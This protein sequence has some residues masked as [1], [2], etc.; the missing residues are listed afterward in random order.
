[1]RSILTNSRSRL[2]DDVHRDHAHCS[3][4]TYDVNVNRLFH[5]LHLQRCISDNH[6]YINTSDCQLVAVTL[7]MINTHSPLLQPNKL[8]DSQGLGAHLPT[9]LPQRCQKC[10]TFQKLQ[11]FYSAPFRQNKKKFYETIKTSS[12]VCT[13]F[14]VCTLAFCSVY[15]LSLYK[16]QASRSVP[17]VPTYH[18]HK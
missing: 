13:Y 6:R 2:S 15:K 1:M 4:A 17:S 18:S 11:Q 8:R 3:Q 9:S 7:Q 12:I 14:F 5:R 10:S 16:N